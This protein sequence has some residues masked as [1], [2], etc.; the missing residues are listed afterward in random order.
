MVTTV[1]HAAFQGHG[2]SAGDPAR[3]DPRPIDR[4]LW[5]CGVVEPNAWGA[6][7][8]R[9]AWWNALHPAAAPAGHARQD[10]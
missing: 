3:S 1:V 10:V 4:S 9:T 5:F 7:A 8:I 2:V 6:H